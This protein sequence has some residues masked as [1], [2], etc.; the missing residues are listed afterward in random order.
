MTLPHTTP[1]PAVG[2]TWIY[3]YDVISDVLTV[4]EVEGGIATCEGRG[5]GRRQMAVSELK[6]VGRKTI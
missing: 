6:L 2:D 1:E 3:P 5:A 4:L